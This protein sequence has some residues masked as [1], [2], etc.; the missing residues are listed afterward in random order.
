MQAG[1]ADVVEPIDRVAQQL[2][3]HRRFFGHRHVRG[4][5]T[6]QR[7]RADPGCDLSL[8]CD[9]AR[10]LVILRAGDC[11]FHRLPSRLI[12]AGDE[13]RVAVPDNLRRNGRDLA[14]GF[15]ES[16]DHFREALPDRAVVIDLRKPKVLKGLVP[17][18]CKDA[19]EGRGRVGASFAN[20][21]EEG[22]QCRCVIEE[23]CRIMMDWTRGVKRPS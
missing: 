21:I 23:H 18:S 11:R 8:E 5:G 1:D 19:V 2:R 14:R 13:Q 22:A 10:N 9:A 7:D 20:V 12:R 16:Q 4:A 3:R 15:S 17:K 6:T